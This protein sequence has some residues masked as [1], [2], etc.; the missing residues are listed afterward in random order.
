MPD[1]LDRT[2]VFQALSALKQTFGP[3]FIIGLSGGGD[4]LALA[5][6]CAAWAKPTDADVL[7]LIVDHGFRENS[8]AEA[9]QGALWAKSFGLQVVIHRHNGIKP[10]TGLQDVARHLRHTAFAQKAHELG[11]ATIL[12]AHTLDD[13]AE[14][15]AFRLARQTGIDG[16]SGMAR[17]TTDLIGWGEQNYPIA[18][19]LLGIRRQAL[20]AYLTDLNQAWIDD[21][22]NEDAGFSR[23]AIRQRLAFLGQHE[24]LA[25]IG[26]LARVLRS[27][28]DQAASALLES[29]LEYFGDSGWG[30][31]VDEI[32]KRAPCIQSRVLSLLLAQV[33]PSKFPI[34]AKK[35][36][37]LLIHLRQ[38]NFKTRTLAG[39]L[40]RVRE[41]RVLVSLAPARRQVGVSTN[42]NELGMQ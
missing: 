8:F 5:H 7:A 19:P 14:T 4:S 33:M 39:S 32:L 9:Q 38:P 11:G 28:L 16:L 20:R 30:L 37:A 27:Q 12:L 31:K 15:I 21:P 41:G 40:I 17:V 3:R 13:Q 26:D 34:A 29:H 10:K 25:R 24:Q 42:G 35:L 6:L 36:D 2:S 22:S 18:R 23:V 1:H